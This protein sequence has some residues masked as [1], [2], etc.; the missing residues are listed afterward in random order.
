MN[1]TQMMGAEAGERTH[2]SKGGGDAPRKLREAFV[3]WAYE[4][5]S[6][7]EGGSLRQQAVFHK[8]KLHNL[9]WLIGRLWECTEPMPVYLCEQLAMESGST[10]AQGVRSVRPLLKA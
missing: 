6:L 10:Y 2:D 9:N 4:R 5:N 3:D 7:D 1:E 8:G